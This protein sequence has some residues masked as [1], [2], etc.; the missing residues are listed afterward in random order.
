M[1]TVWKVLCDPLM[2]GNEK[3]EMWFL[4]CDY[5]VWLYAGLFQIHSSRT[6]PNRTVCAERGGERARRK[7][8]CWNRDS[9]MLTG[10][11]IAWGGL[12]TSGEEPGKLAPL[13][14]ALWTW[15]NFWWSVC[16]SFTKWVNDCCIITAKATFGFFKNYFCCL[17][18][19]VT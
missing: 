14:P 15:L 13:C 5:N 6:P 8:R 12:C 10:R 7:R 11:N 16:S 4:M 1:I 18:I 3:F 19:W 17:H 2:K 9:L